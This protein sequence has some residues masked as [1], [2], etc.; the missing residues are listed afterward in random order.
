MLCAR[1]RSDR[2]YPRFRRPGA[3]LRARPQ[4]RRGSCAHIQRVHRQHGMDAIS[5]TVQSVTR[6]LPPSRQPLEAQAS[7]EVSSIRS[8]R[9]ERMHAV[10]VPRQPRTDREATGRAENAPPRV[11]EFWSRVFPWQDRTFGT[12][13]A[14]AISRCGSPASQRTP[15]TSASAARRRATFVRRRHLAAFRVSILDTYRIRA[16]CRSGADRR[17]APMPRPGNGGWPSKQAD[18]SITYAVGDDPG[19]PLRRP[20]GRVG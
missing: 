4:R 3:H 18:H 17:P 2:E 19:L 11:A 8:A 15:A 14:E 13:S 1:Q 9:A 20:R 7:S 10:T 5:R 6:A 16:R 12:V